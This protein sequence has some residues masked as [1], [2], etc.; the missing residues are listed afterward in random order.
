MTQL[1]GVVAHT[2]QANLFFFL[3]DFAFKSAELS[4]FQVNN[5]YKYYLRELKH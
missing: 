4:S 5:R 1:A 3:F 2:H